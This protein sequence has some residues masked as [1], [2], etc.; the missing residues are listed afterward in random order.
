MLMHAFVWAVAL[1]TAGALV[2]GRQL[3]AES[4]STL[5]LVLLS[6]N[7]ILSTR[8][9]ILE[10]RLEGLDKLFVTHRLIGLTVGVLVITHL[11]IVPKSVGYIAS[12]PVGYTTI[13]V[14][15]TAIFIA[16]APRFPWRG[17]VPLKY[18][19]WKSTHRFMGL[20]VA[21]AVL[22]SL[23]A[24]TYVRRVPLLAVYVY[25]IAALGL[26]AWSYRETVFARVGPFRRCTVQQ[27]RRLGDDVLELTLASE[28]GPYIRTPGQFVFASSAAGPSK[29]Q[30]PFT[31]SSGPGAEVRFSI[32]ASGDFTDALVSGVP[33]DSGIRIEGPYGAFNFRRG[34]QRQVWLAGGIGITP[35]LAMAADLDVGREVTLIWSIRDRSE[36]V[37]SGELEALSRDASGL[38]VVIHPTSE[39]G[40]L[41]LAPLPGS[42]RAAEDL[43]VFICGPLPMRREFI[44]QL[45]ALGIPRSEIYFEEFRLR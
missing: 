16:S 1:L 6:C 40:H 39:L 7:L 31:I 34:R 4:I 15:L 32:K 37:Y 17:L 25:T 22:H 18:Q 2:P 10:K 29:E 35:F 21:A 12:K 45:G 41:D 28:A 23:L 13:A 43:S 33:L 26:L 27:C 20:V 5:A 3:V 30:H 8:A 11:S 44:R 24:P 38:T 19:T 9:P 36:A 14:L 42:L